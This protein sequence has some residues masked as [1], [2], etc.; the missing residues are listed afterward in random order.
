MNHPFFPGYRAC[1]CVS[2]PDPNVRNEIALVR[3]YTHYIWVW[4]R[5]YL[6]MM[7]MPFVVLR[8]QLVSCVRRY[9]YPAKCM[10][11]FILN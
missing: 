5:E 11:I 2:Y 7:V 4:V 9:H 1:L 10:F 8:T 6:L 3:G